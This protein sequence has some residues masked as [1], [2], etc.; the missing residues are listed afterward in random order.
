VTPPPPRSLTLS[1]AAVLLLPELLRNSHTYMERQGGV[2]RTLQR[3][4]IEEWASAF[5]HKPTE[6][7]HLLRQRPL[8]TSRP[9]ALS[10][11]QRDMLQP[12][13]PLSCRV[14]IPS[15]SLHRCP[16]TVACSHCGCCPY[17]VG[18]ALALLAPG[19]WPCRGSDP[20]GLCPAPIAN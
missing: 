6:V 17:R 2:A 7:S 11:P 1:E 18:Y 15:V 9:A 19:D 14:T 16:D 8:Q 10:F 20:K 3:L 12:R 13:C 5:G 4:G